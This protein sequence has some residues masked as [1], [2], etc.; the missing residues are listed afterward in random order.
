MC[1]VCETRKPGRPVSSLKLWETLRNTPG[2]GSSLCKFRTQTEMQAEFW[3][4]AHRDRKLW[5]ADLWHSK[6]QEPPARGRD[7][8]DTAGAQGSGKRE[9]WET[10]DLHTAC[11]V[12]VQ[13]P[14][15]SFARDPPW[16][17]QLRLFVCYCA[18][19]KLFCGMRHLR[20]CLGKSLW[21]WGNSGGATVGSV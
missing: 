2:T 20:P 7:T 8:G 17:H 5:A 12:R 14:R 21:E 15:G 4:R 18:V 10:W 16:W 6:A 9:V 19:N 1:L 11:T 3:V 13:K